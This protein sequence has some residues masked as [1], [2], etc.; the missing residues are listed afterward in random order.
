MNVQVYN[1]EGWKII[2]ETVH[3]DV[4]GEFRPKEMNRI[5]FVLVVWDDNQPIGYITCTEYDSES[6][7]IGYGGAM[8][9]KKKTYQVLIGYKLCLTY[10]QNKYSRV[11]TLIENTNIS[12]IKMAMS[13]GFVVTGIRF[14]KGSV[15]LENS[16]EWLKE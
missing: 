16:I 15:M 7:Y 5:D 6:V 10:L 3:F 1:S 14:F 8:S 11:N 12:M 2:S 4:F 9:H 13:V